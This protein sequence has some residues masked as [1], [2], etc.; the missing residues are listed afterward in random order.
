[1]KLPTTVK[2]LCS[3]CSRLQEWKCLH[4]CHVGRI[5][6]GTCRAATLETREGYWLETLAKCLS[7]EVW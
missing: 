7:G 5:S 1:M 3:V 6:T 4:G 2:A